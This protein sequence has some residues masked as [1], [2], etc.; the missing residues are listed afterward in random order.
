M[1]EIGTKKDRYR[2]GT[3]W[4]PL[5]LRDRY[6]KAVSSHS[7]FKNIVEYRCSAY[8]I[9]ESGDVKKKRKEEKR[10]EKRRKEKKRKEKKKRK[11][12]ALC[13]V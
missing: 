7:F 4:P 5:V 3:P 13:S 2:V 12:A 8:N 9:L 10:E 1:V 11:E 6:Y